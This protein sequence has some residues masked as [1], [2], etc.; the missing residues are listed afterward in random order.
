MQTIDNQQL[1]T[2]TGGNY[3][4]AG[5]ACYA[6]PGARAFYGPYPAYAPRAAWWPGYAA[7]NPYAAGWY[8]PPAPARRAWWW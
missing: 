6:A 3:Y 5:P 1:A 8:G 4:C 2:M 7:Y